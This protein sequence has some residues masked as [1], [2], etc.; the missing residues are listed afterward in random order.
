MLNINVRSYVETANGGTEWVD[1]YTGRNTKKALDCVRK[2]RAMNEVIDI[3]VGFY[4]EFAGA[5]LVWTDAIANGTNHPCK[6]IRIT[7]KDLPF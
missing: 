4:Q 6:V 3:D 5:Q 1:N 2:L 7:D